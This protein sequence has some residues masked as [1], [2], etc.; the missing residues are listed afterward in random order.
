MQL[1]GLYSTFNAGAAGTENPQ[2]LGQ[3]MV[4]KKFM[5]SLDYVSMRQDTALLGAR[6]PAGTFSR[7]ISNPGNAYALYIHHS[8]L[9]C[10]FWEPMQ[11]GACYV[12][13]PGSYREKLRLKISPGNYHAEW[14][15]PATSLVI[16][17][18]DFT[19]ESELHELETPE[20]N[21]DIALRILRR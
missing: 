2:L 8:R 5:N 10:W 9:G 11:M 15:D 12:T 4:L 19:Q 18:D 6:K 20:Y 7:A 14:V 13:E 1:N 17:T 16:R 21:I 3:L